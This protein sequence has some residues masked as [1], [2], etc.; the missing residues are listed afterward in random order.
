MKGRINS[1]YVKFHGITLHVQ[2]IFDAI[3]RVN[4]YVENRF[5][6]HIKE[7]EVKGSIMPEFSLQLILKS[8]KTKED[9]FLA[10]INNLTYFL[11]I[12]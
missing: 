11:A 5:Q 6:M 10:N 4:S 7:K 1:D 3:E 8:G 9:A 12:L 2:K